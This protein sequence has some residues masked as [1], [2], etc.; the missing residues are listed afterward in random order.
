[1]DNVEEELEVPV[2]DSTIWLNA[3]FVY[4]YRLRLPPVGAGAFAGLRVLSI[5]VGRVS[6]GDLR[7]VIS[8]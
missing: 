7:C 8:T 2:L 4:C 5:N 3:K 1:V 6:G